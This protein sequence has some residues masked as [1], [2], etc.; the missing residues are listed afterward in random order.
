MQ[1][2]RADVHT[3]SHRAGNL[4]TRPRSY[5]PPFERREIMNHVSSR[6][7]SLCQRDLCMDRQIVR[8]LDCEASF[9]R[10]FLF[11]RGFVRKAV[12]RIS[13]TS[14]DPKSLSP[15]IIKTAITQRR[16]MDPNRSSE[17]MHMRD[18]EPSGRLLATIIGICP[19]DLSNCM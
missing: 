17:K 18:D 4:E 19:N 2:R 15:S 13:T 7:L 6:R 14:T 11:D 8:H 10:S 3:L 9:G 5:A 12:R 1:S 16:P